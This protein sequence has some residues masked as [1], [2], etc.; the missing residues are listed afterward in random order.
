MKYLHAAITL[1]CLSPGQI[2]SLKATAL[3]QVRLNSAVPILTVWLSK[4]PFYTDFSPL[5][6]A[7][8]PYL[9]TRAVGSNWK[10]IMFLGIN[11]CV[12][13]GWGLMSITVTTCCWQQQQPERNIH[14]DR[15]RFLLTPERHDPSAEE[16]RESRRE[17][18]TEDE[19]R[20]KKARTLA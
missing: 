11:T 3:L 14:I 12:L 13:I 6:T 18:E 7:T 10:M 1:P 16:G 15:N 5:G 2:F 8:A 17:S 9:L 19:H 20:H 4:L